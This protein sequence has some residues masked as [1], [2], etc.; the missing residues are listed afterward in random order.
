[1]NLKSVCCMFAC[2]CV[3]LVQPCLCPAQ[4]EESADK[5]LELESGLYYTVRKG[6]TLWDLSQ[7]FYDSPWVWPDLWE[8]NKEIPNPHWIYPGQIVRIYT[9]AEIEAMLAGEE[10]APEVVVE[11]GEGP[12]YFY[13]GID[14]V[15]FLRETPADAWGAIFEEVEDKDLLS[16]GDL[17][18]IRPLN[19]HAF[20]AGTRFKAFR[21]PT[22]FV[23]EATKTTY[24]IQHLMVGI[25]EI[26][27]VHPKFAI[28]RI[29]ESYRTLK[30]D[31]RLIP[32][33]ERSPKIYLTPSKPGLKGT[34]IAPQ[35]VI[36]MFAKYFVVFIDRG[37]RDGVE[38]GQLYNVYSQKK[39]RLDPESEEETLLP[40]VDYAEIIVLHVEETTAT[41]LITYSERVIEAGEKFQSGRKARTARK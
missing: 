33:E 28:G 41:A 38:V 18:Y 7:R 8:K 35:I 17:I 36:S 14:R 23:D 15:G 9:K 21:M 30:L 37:E 31:D 19:G 5:S 34:I 13:P 40:P 4:E 11:P 12:F 32:Y 27:E 16:T 29:V 26:T 1:M 10:P 3:G 22:T 24:G 20:E 39:A 2:L 6:D 25:V